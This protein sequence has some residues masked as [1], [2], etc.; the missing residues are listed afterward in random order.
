MREWVFIAGLNY[1]EMRRVG[2]KIGSLNSRP[3]SMLSVLKS[4]SL[5]YHIQNLR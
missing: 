5:L 2:L 4:G 3:V 1:N